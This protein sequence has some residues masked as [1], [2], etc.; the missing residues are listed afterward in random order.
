MA[1]AAAA[2]KIT[3]NVYF[4]VRAHSESN[5]L[6]AAQALGSSRF[7]QEDRFCVARSPA[8]L[9]VDEASMRS[10]FDILM[11]RCRESK[12]LQGHREELV[13]KAAGSCA[14]IV[15]INRERVIVGSMGDSMAFM[16]E[17]EGERVK[18]TL[19]NALH[20]LNIES[21]Q[22][23][24]SENGIAFEVSRGGAV[25]T[26]GGVNVVA[27]IGDGDQKLIR[28]P[29]IRVFP[30]AHGSMQT[31]ALACDGLVEVPTTG[32]TDSE[33]DIARRFQDLWL[34]ARERGTATPE[35]NF[36]GILNQLA[37]ERGSRDN[38]SSI[39]LDVEHCSGTYCLAIFDGHGGQA[40][41]NT[42]SVCL[43]EA[44]DQLYPHQFVQDFSSGDMHAVNPSPKESLV[45][46]A[47]Q[48]L[49]SYEVKKNPFTLQDTVDRKIVAKT[50]LMGALKFLS[51]ENIRLSG[52]LGHTMYGMDYES[53][54]AARAKETKTCHFHTDEIR[55]EALEELIS[56][57]LKSESRVWLQDKASR[58][59]RFYEILQA[60]MP[61]VIRA[62]TTPMAHLAMSGSTMNP[63]G[64]SNAA[65]VAEA[66][67]SSSQQDISMH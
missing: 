34:A 37:A 12:V 7:D 53:P 6:T 15:L 56:S 27:A 1:S 59:N 2:P 16:V 67:G 65:A 33:E 10:L 25:R 51:D 48:E 61:Q 4:E 17:P 8:D 3:N 19:L 38:L 49:S 50:I 29:D 44:L 23:L 31:L 26:V 64:A 57:V 35:R 62:S 46:S 52:E 42:L 36:A 54:Q 32:T 20:N 58:L 24:A 9:P 47:L 14:L 43:A 63:S 60:Y 22:K 55:L 28:K 39:V 11:A 18:A 40:V 41:S 30:R 66:G 5:I 21:A 13:E 45:Q